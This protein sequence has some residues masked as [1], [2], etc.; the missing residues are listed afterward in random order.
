MIRTTVSSPVFL[1]SGPL[2]ARLIT[3][4]TD[5]L[6]YGKEK[7]RAGNL[8]ILAGRIILRYAPNERPAKGSQ[9]H[10]HAMQRQLP[11]DAREC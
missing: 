2:N 7:R 4:L 5:F 9:S 10:S 11:G 8:D 3:D 6:G 1:R